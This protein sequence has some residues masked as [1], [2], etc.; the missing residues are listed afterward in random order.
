MY[1][2]SDD[3]VLDVEF[4]IVIIIKN[5]WIVLF[6]NI[7]VPINF[8]NFLSQTYMFIDG[9]YLLLDNYWFFPKLML[10]RSQ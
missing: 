5:Q 10:M 9:D 2:K 4:I 7:Y 8:S 1:V 3:R 6:F